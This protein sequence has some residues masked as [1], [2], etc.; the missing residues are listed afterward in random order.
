MSASDVSAEVF[1]SFWTSFVG[2]FLSGRSRLSAT[3]EIPFRQTIQQLAV[4]PEVQT[5][6]S[7]LHLFSV[8]S[9]FSAISCLEFYWFLS[10]CPHKTSNDG[11]CADNIPHLTKWKCLRYPNVLRTPWKATRRFTSGRPKEGRPLNLYAACLHEGSGKSV[12]RPSV[13]AGAT[14]AW[15]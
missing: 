1:C 2:A 10:L 11:S 14:W 9:T 8:F 15:H 7:E 6:Q 12:G 13:V 5:S 3:K 4:W